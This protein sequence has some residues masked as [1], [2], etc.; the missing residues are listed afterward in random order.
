[1]LKNIF[2]A[3]IISIS[4]NCLAQNDLNSYMDE[5]NGGTVNDLDSSELASESVDSNAKTTAAGDTIGGCRLAS[6]GSTWQLKESFITTSCASV[7]GGVNRFNKWIDLAPSL[8]ATDDVVTLCSSTGPDPVYWQY[9][10][11][12]T[13]GSNIYLTKCLA[14]NPQSGLYTNYFSAH[15]FRRR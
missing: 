13:G 11:Q 1:M 9:I 3:S 10:G 5:Y 15:Q 4:L 12:S 7:R 2:L 8:W 14:Y 6:P